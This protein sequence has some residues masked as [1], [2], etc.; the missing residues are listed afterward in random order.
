MAK[1]NEQ[2]EVKVVMDT[3]MCD[4]V[5]S[6]A[7][8]PRFSAVCP[9]HI[10][11]ELQKEGVLGSYNLV[12]A[13]DIVDNI[14][15]Y[16]ELFDYTKTP[17]D[18]DSR[19]HGG[20]RTSRPLGQ[21]TILDNSVIELGGAVSLEMILEA[22]VTVKANVIVLPD[23]LRDSKGTIESGLDAYELWTPV[24]E[25]YLT[26]DWSYMVVPQLDKDDTAFGLK[27][28][29]RCAEAFISQ[30]RINWWGCPRNLVEPL[31]TRADALKI[32]RMLDYTKA[33][34]MLGFSDNLIDDFLC[35][36]D[37]QNRV[38]G[39]DSAVPLRAASKGVSMRL[40]MDTNTEIGPRGGWWN[41][42]TFDPLMVENMK[43][44]KSWLS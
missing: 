3:K 13:H 38:M 42:V 14:Q 29:I 44:V 40:S 39:I 20:W 35:A 27:S 31:G 8:M 12:L 34:H 10:A 24:L 41:N 7:R 32:L 18:W 21:V 5:A 23:V 15:A 30:P 36:T 28:F 11:K 22:A 37:V 26:W 33:V 4:A 43:A 2:M 19:T 1:M 9:A 25:R 17:A 6:Y 16:G